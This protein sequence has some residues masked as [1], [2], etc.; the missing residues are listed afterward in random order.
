[1]TAFVV[2]MLPV[3]VL[4]GLWQSE[5]AAY[6]DELETQFGA[7]LGSM[8]AALGRSAT[9]ASRLRRLRLFG[10]YG[11]QRLLLDNQIHEG[12]VGYWLLQSFTAEADGTLQQVLVNR[13]WLAAPARRDQLPALPPTPAGR[14]SLIALQ[15]PDLGALPSFGTPQPPEALD[16]ELWRIQRIDWPAID[17][18]VPGL[19]SA[20]MRLEAGQPGVLVAAPARLG[21]GADRHRGYAFQWFGLALTLLIGY[22]VYGYKSS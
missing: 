22:I 17:T 10:R 2:V 12:Q 19:M 8:P 16:D 13:G 15:W 20:E 3:L 4:L 21:F 5:R 18:L 7:T 11:E 14:Q 9:P 6:K 1:M